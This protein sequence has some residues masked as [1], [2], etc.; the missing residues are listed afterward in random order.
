M[1]EEKADMRNIWGIASIF[2]IYTSNEMKDMQKKQYRL[3]YSLI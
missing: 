3:L 1:T 2:L